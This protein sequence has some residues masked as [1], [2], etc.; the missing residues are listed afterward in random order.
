MAGQEP[1][2]VVD[3]RWRMIRVGAERP[4][5]DKVYMVAEAYMDDDGEVTVRAYLK[6]VLE[7]LI[8]H[9]G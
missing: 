2:L 9:L 4:N 6:E 5:G 3:R 1:R 7:K 8:K